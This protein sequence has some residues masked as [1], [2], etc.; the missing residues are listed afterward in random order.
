MSEDTNEEGRPVRRFLER[1]VDPDNDNNFCSPARDLVVIEFRLTFE[2][3]G[4]PVLRGVMLATA[5]CTHC[6]T[7]LNLIQL[8]HER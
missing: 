6:N 1:A 2:W 4:S 3:L 7:T 8:L 5:E